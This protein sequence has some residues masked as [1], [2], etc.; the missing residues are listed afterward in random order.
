MMG[1]LFLLLLVVVVVVLVS[2]GT[3]PCSLRAVKMMVPVSSPMRH[4]AMRVG[5][6][7]CEEE[8]RPFCNTV[9]E[10]NTFATR[11]WPLVPGFSWSTFVKTGFRFAG[12]SP[13]CC[14]LVAEAIL[15]F[16]W[17]MDGCFFGIRFPFLFFLWLALCSVCG[18]RRDGKEW[19]SIKHFSVT[20]LLEIMRHVVLEPNRPILT[21][22]VIFSSNLN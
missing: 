14:C 11:V 8:G 17:W 3:L 7:L 9:L 5:R 19:K 13:S 18:I 22:V 15:R 4:S 1:L 21:S 12:F 16:L 6:M 20:F 10:D 2:S